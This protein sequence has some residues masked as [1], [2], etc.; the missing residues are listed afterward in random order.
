ML[1]AHLDQRARRIGRQIAGKA[2]A[3]FTQHI[4]DDGAA[5]GGAGR[6]V[7]LIERRQAQH[8]LGVDRV[9]VAQP[10]FDFGNREAPGRAA[11]GGFGVGRGSA[12]TCSG[13]S[14]LRAQAR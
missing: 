10:V 8:V 5:F 14:R 11:R 9:R 2:L 13:R 6:G 4:V 12:F 7:D 3:E 1:S